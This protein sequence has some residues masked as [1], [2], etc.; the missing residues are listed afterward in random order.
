MFLFTRVGELGGREGGKEG[1]KL[2]YLTVAGSLYRTAS[3]HKTWQG[4]SWTNTG[5]FY[6]W[7]LGSRWTTPVIALLGNAEAE[8]KREAGERWCWMLARLDFTVSF[9]LYSL[10]FHPLTLPQRTFHNGL[11]M[12]PLFLEDPPG[13]FYADTYLLCAFFWMLRLSNKVECNIQSS[14]WG[15][16][17]SIL[18]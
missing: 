16:T 18:F 8:K 2:V 17:L 7:K 5:L 12:P 10:W 13:N 15:N 14:I 4:W 1:G 9:Y 6:D 11:L 3:P